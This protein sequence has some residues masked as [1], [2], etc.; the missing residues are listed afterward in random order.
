[1]PVEHLDQFGEVREGAGQAVNLIDHHDLDPARLHL[2]KK[3]L[4]SWPA[5]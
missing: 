5:E 2:G 3:Y 1:M 4:E